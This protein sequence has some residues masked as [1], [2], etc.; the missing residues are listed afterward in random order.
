MPAWQDLVAILAAYVLGCFA[1]AYYLV[2]VWKGQDIR[3]L[4]S[5]TVGGRN[6]GR[7][8]GPP[9]FVIVVAGDVL[10]G[11]LAVLL[12]RWLGAQS[13]ALVAAMAAVVAGH[14]WPAQLGFHGGKGAAT[15]MGALIGYDIRIALVVVVLFVILFAIFRSFTVGGLLA[16]VLTPL[17]LL[18]LSQPLLSVAAVLAPVLVVLVA[19]RSNI[20]AKLHSRPAAT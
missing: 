16:L 20:R 13:W 10:K 8:L 6:A 15:M 7:I 5:G 11:V 9:G 19:H 12:A 14:V 1:T 2:R 3:Q 17:A 18:L 4:G